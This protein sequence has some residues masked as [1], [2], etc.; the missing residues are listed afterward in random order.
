MASLYLHIPFCEHKCI[1]CDFYSIES[2]DPIESF[3]VALRREIQSYADQGGDEAF[4]TIFFGGGTPSLLSPETISGLIQQLRDTYAVN[5]D[6]EVT[7]E[8]NPGTIDQAKL[9]GY[10]RA[11]V[12][13][14]SF[15]VQSFHEDDLRF[16]TR[17]H[18]SAQAVDA[19]KMARSAGFTNLNLDFIFALP[20]QS[21]ERW[22]SNLEQAVSLGPEHISAYSLIVEKGTPLERLVS[23]KQVSTLPLGLEAEL[24]EFTMEYLARSG[25]EHY[26]VS[27]YARPGF[28]SRHNSN[29]WNHTN[30]L[31][32]GPSAHSFWSNHRWWNISN[33]RTYSERIVA[34]ERPVTGEEDLTS[35]QL[36]EELIMLGLRSSGV[37]LARL[38]VDC[39]FDLLQTHRHLVD[40]LVEERLVVL[41]RAMLKLTDKGFLICDEIVERLL[42]TVPAF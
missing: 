8:T 28:H 11:G 21:M 34:G 6:A 24:Y 31:G 33:L 20:R 9:E 26:E 22:K 4:E 38:R 14:L 39:R 32:F 30:Y 42:P 25:Y 15:G 19:V 35:H 17:I 2:L 41:E 7:L 37:D 29:Y 10:Q 27:N 12:N 18:S 5:P 3:L 16:L 23:S 1:Y 40:G 13:R 36:A